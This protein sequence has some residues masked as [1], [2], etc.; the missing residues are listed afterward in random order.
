MRAEG[1]RQMQNAANDCGVKGFPDN[2]PR[3]TVT[4]PRAG[5]LQRNENTFDFC[6]KVLIR[7]KRRAT[8][9]SP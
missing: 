3:A 9:P 5:Q 4:S 6:Q 2:S 8:D 7:A 1:V